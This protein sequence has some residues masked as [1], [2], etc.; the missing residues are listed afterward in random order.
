MNRIAAI[1]GSA[2]LLIGTS[3]FAQTSNPPQLSPPR[4]NAPG[5]Q[6]P[7]PQTPDTQRPPATSGEAARPV[8]P[9]ERDRIVVPPPADATQNLNPR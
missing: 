8:N 7:Q 5:A 9:A 6:T 4:S 1:A 3:A 2:L